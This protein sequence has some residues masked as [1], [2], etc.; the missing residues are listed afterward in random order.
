MRSGSTEPATVLRWKCP[1]CSTALLW[2]RSSVWLQRELLCLSACRVT[3]ALL[4]RLSLL[5]V[6]G[7]VSGSETLMRSLN[8]C[9]ELRGL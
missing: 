9:Q 7:D 3:E 1:S 6:A 2:T 8:G 5:M 4:Q